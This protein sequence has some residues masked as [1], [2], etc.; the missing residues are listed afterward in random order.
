MTDEAGTAA[1]PR[2]GLAGTGLE[3]STSSSYIIAL[4]AIGVGAY[5]GAWT[6]LG[7]LAMI[8]GVAAVW[9]SCRSAAF[10]VLGFWILVSVVALWP[11]A[12]TSGS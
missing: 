1:A 10:M 6:L 11:T 7:A 2:R 4:T 12:V 3:L 5:F 9:R 8:T